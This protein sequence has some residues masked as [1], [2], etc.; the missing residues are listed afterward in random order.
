LPAGTQ[1]VVLDMH[2]LFLMDTS[3][4][5][6]LK[7]LH[8]SLQRQ[9]VTLTLVDVNEQPLSLIRRS[10]FAAALGAA[11]IVVDWSALAEVQA[12]AHR[13]AA[14]QLATGPDA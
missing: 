9:G 14:R 1:H 13:T 12:S 4:L 10:G 6:A 3:G 11:S 2:H 8:R 5:E 7:Q